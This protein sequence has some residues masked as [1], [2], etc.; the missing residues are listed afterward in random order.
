MRKH[1]HQS[2]MLW[3]SPGKDKWLSTSPCG[4]A[5]AYGLEQREDVGAVAHYRASSVLC[6]EMAFL[7]INALQTYEDRFGREH[8]HACPT[9]DSGRSSRRP[10]PTNNRLKP[11]NKT[12]FAA[13]IIAGTLASAILALGTLAAPAQ[14]KDTGWPIGRFAEWQRHHAEGHRLAGGLTETTN[15]SGSTKAVAIKP[16]AIAFETRIEH[17]ANPP[18]RSVPAPPP[19]PVSSLARA[20]MHPH[21][22]PSL[23][24][25]DMR[26]ARSLRTWRACCPAVEARGRRLR[27]RPECS[28]TSGV[29]RVGAADVLEVLGPVG[30]RGGA[31]HGVAKLEARLN[32]V[33]LLEEAMY[34]A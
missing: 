5:C 28:L 27:R 26:P 19:R 12:R 2:L 20:D 1:A 23:H 8:A 6:R 25:S 3:I 7:Q 15:L 10:A 30:V 4:R 33:L 17:K 16:L 13:R 9:L 32:A 29:V 11:M 18:G 14:A 22:L 21:V 24:C 34:P 31:A